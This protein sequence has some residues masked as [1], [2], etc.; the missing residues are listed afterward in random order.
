MAQ[1]LRADYFSRKSPSP[2][3]VSSIELKNFFTVVSSL[4]FYFISLF[5]FLFVWVNYNFILACVQTSL[6]PHYESFVFALAKSIY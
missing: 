5:F 6:L 1:G 2:S 4:F 3:T